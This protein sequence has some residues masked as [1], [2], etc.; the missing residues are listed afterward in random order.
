M[1]DSRSSI[2]ARVPLRTLD[3]SWKYRDSVG[4]ETSISPESFSIVRMV[5][6]IMP[7]PSAALPLPVEQ[8]GNLIDEAFFITARLDGK[9]PALLQ[10]AD[11]IRTGGEKATP[12]ARAN[13]RDPNRVGF[14]AIHVSDIHFRKIFLYARNR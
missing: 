8:R 4:R 12:S 5:F 11:E 3:G 13:I 7:V 14:A 2:L 9:M 1:V 10:R 6:L